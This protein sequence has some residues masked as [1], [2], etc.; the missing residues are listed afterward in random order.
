MAKSAE[1]AYTNLTLGEA[2]KVFQEPNEQSLREFINSYTESIDEPTVRWRVEDGNVYFDKLNAHR[3]KF[4]S[5]DLI[6]TALF[7][8]QELE[9]IA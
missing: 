9:R 1:K 5:E 4:N 7:Y 3:V 2:L 6:S 8:S